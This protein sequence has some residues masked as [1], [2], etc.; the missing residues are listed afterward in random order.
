MGRVRF[1]KLPQWI[2]IYFSM[3]YPCVK[4]G[5]CCRY[6][7]KSELTKHLDRG[8]GVCKHL[9]DKNNLCT[10]Y[11]E[12]PCVCQIDSFYNYISADI[13]LIEYYK[14]NAKI[15]NDLLIKHNLY[16]RLRVKIKEE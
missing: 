3:S 14:I 16:S 7:F 8:D 2:K 4:C 9:C 1:G 11:D 5:L 10:I 6:I 15:C 13:T 12:R